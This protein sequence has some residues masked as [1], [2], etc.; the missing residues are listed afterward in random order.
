M[1]ETTQRVSRHWKHSLWII[2]ALS[3]ISLLTMSIL[4]DTSMV[5]Q[6]I[7]VVGFSLVSAGSYVSLARYAFQKGGNSLM[8][9]FLAH[10]TLRMLAAAALIF[11]Y[12]NTK[13]WLQT[14]DKKPLLMFVILFA[15]FYL[16]LLI[17]DTV[18]VM[19]WQRTLGN[20]E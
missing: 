9:T 10:S 15:V 20:K 5:E 3:L 16:I 1:N 18:K 12:A 4:Y 19:K 7:V 14:T 17:F 6:L 13:G 2:V 8:K 11:I